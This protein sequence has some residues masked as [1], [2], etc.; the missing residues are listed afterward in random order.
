MDS[1]PKSM[2]AYL[3]AIKHPKSSAVIYD[4]TKG[5]WYVYTTINSTTKEAPIT[6]E[7]A[8]FFWSHSQRILT[9]KK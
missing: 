4:G 1:T 6:M 3:I 8:L 9:L 7:Q 2:R 5:K